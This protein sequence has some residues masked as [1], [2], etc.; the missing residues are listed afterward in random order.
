MVFYENLCPE[1]QPP[2]DRLSPELIAII[3]L[4]DDE[5]AL[6]FVCLVN[7]KGSST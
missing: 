2:C 6:Y 4:S 3:V 7:P 5:V 1:D